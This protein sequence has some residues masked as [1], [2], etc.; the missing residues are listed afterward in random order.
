MSSPYPYG[1]YPPP[2]NPYFQQGG[3]PYSPQGYYQPAY[4]KKAVTNHTFGKLSFFSSATT[5]CIDTNA[6][7]LYSPPPQVIYAPPPYQY[8][9]DNTCCWACLAAM[10]FCCAIEELC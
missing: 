8:Q 9:N 4:V 7:S 2:P 3:Y 5:T 10:C 6:F 1:Q